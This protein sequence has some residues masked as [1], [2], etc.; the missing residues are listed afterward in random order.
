M[1]RRGAR[2]SRPVQYA[3]PFHFGLDGSTLVLPSKAATGLE[4]SHANT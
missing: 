2:R 4:R 3:D 1:R